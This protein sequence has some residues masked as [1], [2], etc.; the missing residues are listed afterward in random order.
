M[1]WL[2]EDV[3]KAIELNRN[4]KRFNEIAIILNRETRGVQIKL[5]KLG[6]GENKTNPN[7][8]LT[9]CNCNKEFTGFKKDKRKFC[10]KSCAIQFN[11]SKYPK[12]KKGE[13]L[14]NCLCCGNP[15]NSH[16]FKF[17][18]YE[19]LGK[20]KWTETV[21]KIENGDTS[22]SSNIYKKYLIEKFGNKC[23]KCGWHE[24]NPT[25]GLVPIQL[26]HKDGNSENHNLN[27]LELLCPNHHSLTPTFGALNK[28]NGRTKRREKRKSLVC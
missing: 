17:C 10:S 14:L 27:N 12:R 26:E 24:V 13:R 25:T 21:N 6:F 23:M 1:K 28:G 5:N 11:N 22:F 19:C 9:C 20:Y 8:T 3:E 16:Q 4:G 7:E 18:S 2:K 15:L